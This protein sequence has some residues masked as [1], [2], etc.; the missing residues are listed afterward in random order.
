LHATSLFSFSCVRQHFIS[1]NLTS[2]SL[3]FFCIVF[4][5]STQQTIYDSATGS[6]LRHLKVHCEGIS[7]MR[8]TTNK[9]LLVGTT[10]GRILTLEL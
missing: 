2:H 10:D 4:H 5:V 9:S 6:P 7:H 3:S 1:C 8:F